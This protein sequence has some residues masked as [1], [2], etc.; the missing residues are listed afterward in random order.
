MSVRALA[1]SRVRVQR[2][3]KTVGR[4]LALLAIRNSGEGVL[5][6]I[7]WTELPFGSI[8]TKFWIWQAH[9]C[10]TTPFYVNEWTFLLPI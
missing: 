7:R 8:L 2:I 3:P 5:K 6:L 10:Y 1:V 9:F 4:G